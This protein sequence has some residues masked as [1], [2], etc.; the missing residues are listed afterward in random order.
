MTPDDLRWPL[1]AQLMTPELGKVLSATDGLR[2]PLI[3]IERH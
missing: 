1:M 3:S 2:A